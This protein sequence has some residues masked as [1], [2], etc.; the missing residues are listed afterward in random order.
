MAKKPTDT[1]SLHVTKQAK[2][3]RE[4]RKRLEAEGWFE[5]SWIADLIYCGVCLTMAFVGTY[6][7]RSHPIL[8]VLLIGLASE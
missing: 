6:L 5:R 2:A 7:A 8:A 4:F 3:F 1:K